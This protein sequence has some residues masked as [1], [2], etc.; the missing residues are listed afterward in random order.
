MKNKF[1][2]PNSQSLE[3]DENVSKTD[4]VRLKKSRIVVILIGFLCCLVLVGFISR[5]VG[6]ACDAG[7]KSEM[8][9]QNL[10]PDAMTKPKVDVR[11]P[12]AILPISYSLKF[13][14]FIIPDN[15]TFRGEARIRL[16]VNE[17]TLNITLHSVD[18]EIADSD[19]TIYKLKD[20]EQDK[21]VDKTGHKF[22]KEKEFLIIEMKEKL[23]KDEKYLL[24]IKFIGKLNENMQGFYRSSYKEGNETRLVDVVFPN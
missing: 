19:I 7:N 16:Q 13:I 2:L 20:G 6:V 4:Y 17:E 11:L 18:L 21:E 3:M 5:N 22:I 23:K 1:R 14:P 24:I 15:F 12:R 9:E 8:S 10:V